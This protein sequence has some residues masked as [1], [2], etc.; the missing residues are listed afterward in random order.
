MEENSRNNFPMRRIRNTNRPI[1]GMWSYT[2]P[3]TQVKLEDW[4]WN[5]FLKKIRDHRT[6]CNLPIEPGWIDE[7]HE[8]VIND[9]PGIEFDDLGS[10]RKW[11]TTDDILR[12]ITTMNELRNGGG[13]VDD[14]E[15]ARRLDICATCP[16]NSS[17]SC[18][19]CG[20]LARELTSMFGKRRVHRSS[21]VY[22]RSCTACGC[23]IT[24]KAAIDLEVLKRVD[25]K[26]GRAP[27]YDPGCWMLTQTT[28]QDH[29]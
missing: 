23:D 5:A 9:K 15:H 12:F 26:L 2:Q 22:G 21:E 11:F 28:P 4:N 19:S 8:Y 29:A 16:K 13:L 24:S 17:I 3:E 10:K 18:A 27:D 20:R 14:M 25:D 1:G 6:A 7:I